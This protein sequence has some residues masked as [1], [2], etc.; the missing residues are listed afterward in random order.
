MA[1]EGRWRN[2]RR[3]GLKIRWSDTPCG[4]ESHPPYETLYPTY[5]NSS[6]WYAYRVQSATSNP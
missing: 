5:P 6:G 2:G 4:F 1:V 3:C